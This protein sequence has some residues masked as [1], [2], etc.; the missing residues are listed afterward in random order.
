[1]GHES[2][3]DFFEG[4]DRGW[5]EPVEPCQ[6]RA[7][8]RDGKGFASHGVLVSMQLHLIL[9][10]V[11]VVY[12]VFR[13]V[14]SFDLRHFELCWEREVQNPDCERGFRFL[15]QSIHGDWGS[16]FYCL[17]HVAELLLDVLEPLL[18]R[19][20]PLPLLIRGWLITS[21]VS[22]RHPLIATISGRYVGLMLTDLLPNDRKS[23]SNS[24]VTS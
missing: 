5:R 7:L 15:N 22:A 3:G 2:N 12:V 13:S 17:L 24:I 16:T 10:G 19:L 20:F 6:G 9:V 8:K 4:R 1:M 11:E 23:A 14:G 18:P 21:V